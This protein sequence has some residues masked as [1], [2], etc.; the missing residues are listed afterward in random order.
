MKITSAEF[1]TSSP[2]LQG[3]PPAQLPE[4]AFIGRSNVGK[5][6]LINMLTGKKDLAKVSGTPGKTRLLN[7]FPINRK[8]M[9]VDL[10]GYGFAKV[11]K[12]SSDEFNAAVSDYLENREG[13]VLSFALIDA[14][15][16]PQDI[17]L[18]FLTWAT[19]A[20]LPVAVIFT[21]TEKLSASALGRAM[22]AFAEAR[23]GLAI[24]EPVAEFAT[25][26]KTSAGRKEVLNFIA[27]Q[28]AQ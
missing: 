11:A 25:S 26:A 27:S 4:F 2:D 6:S 3:C 1:L 15:I 17:D 12:Q 24:A 14:R 21:K 7:F 8:W 9:L 20:E 5:S 10:P 19:A 28:L 23:Q 16:P 22:S 18:R 13:L